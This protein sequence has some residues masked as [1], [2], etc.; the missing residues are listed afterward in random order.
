MIGVKWRQKRSR[1]G[2]LVPDCWETDCGYTVAKVRVADD[3]IYQV[4]PP[5]GRVPVAHAR[6]QDEVL[7]VIVMD[8]EL[9]NE[10]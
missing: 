8:K 10:V 9:R 7:K 5:H 2:D 3:A 4:T 6:T 1:D